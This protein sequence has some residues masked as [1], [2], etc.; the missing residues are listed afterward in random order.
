MLDRDYRCAVAFSKAHFA[1]ADTRYYLLEIK[2]VEKYLVM[3][4]RGTFLMPR[5]GRRLF[6]KVCFFVVIAELFFFLRLL[7]VTL[8]AH[9]SPPLRK[10]RFIIFRPV[11]I[12]GRLIVV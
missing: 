11:I 9:A 3:F 6:S 5:V 4:F 7:S 10:R 1:F 8:S 2:T 12:G